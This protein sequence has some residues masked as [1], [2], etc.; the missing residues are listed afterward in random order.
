MPLVVITNVIAKAEINIGALCLIKFSK[1][2]LVK[3]ASAEMVKN[4]STTKK[5]KKILIT[6]AFSCKNNLY[7]FIINVLELLVTPIYLDQALE[8]FCQPHLFLQT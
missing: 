4:K 3:K 1:F 5:N 8:Y 2:L 6:A 7:S